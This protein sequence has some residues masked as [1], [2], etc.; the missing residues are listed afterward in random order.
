MN[1]GFRFCALILVSL[2]SAV[3]VQD[4]KV[5]K[6]PTLSSKEKQEIQKL[7][8]QYISA[9]ADDDRAGILKKIQDLEAGKVVSQSELTTL[10]QRLFALLRQGTMHDGKPVWYYDHP[11]GK[12]KVLVQNIKKG[13]RPGLFIGLHGGGEGV[14]DSEQIAQLFGTGVAGCIAVY[15]TVIK[16]ETAAWNT[17]R[18]TE[19]VMDL[20]EI[21]KR[22][23]NIDTNR[24]YLAGHS[25][26]G[27]GTW[28]IGTLHSD[29]FA[30]ISP[31]AG[32]LFVMGSDI[33]RGTVENL[34]NT[35]IWFFHSTDDPRV[36]PQADQAAA[37][38]LKEYNDKY[39][40]YDFVWKEYNDIG[41]GFPKDGVGPIWKWL[42]T[43]V[44]NPFPKFVIW[45]PRS[46][47]KRHFYWLKMEQ[48]R[49]RVEAKIDGNKISLEG[50]FSGLEIML[51]EKML[52]LKKPVTIIR[53]G[54]EVAKLSP[55]FSYATL[56]ETIV[57]KK[58]P[59]M[60]FCA[61]LAVPDDK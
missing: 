51:N 49:G 13:G 14:G 6:P 7:C 8:E 28:H 24:I 45:E 26:G 4:K 23:Y 58:D 36:G 57:A 50:N 12:G 21:M 44:R 61:K 43:K 10:A 41:H 39:G 42:G 35:P 53:A 33:I 27:Y 29:V 38:K 37:K 54:K 55:I 47:K 9:K 46:T 30:A 22:T 18:E 56:A 32:G 25:M 1:K 5:E 34:K 3:N 52:D 17:E 15:P 11:E 48:P 2:F 19:Y 16:K 60:Y 31:M 40:P 20:I 59:E